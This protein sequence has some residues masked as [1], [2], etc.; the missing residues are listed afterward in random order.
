M[1]WNSRLPTSNEPPRDASHF[2]V[3]ELQMLTAATAIE[4][5]MRRWLAAKLIA[6]ADQLD[7]LAAGQERQIADWQAM[8]RDEEERA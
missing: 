7:L 8:I 2:R 6:E 4:A 5:S 1:G 3:A